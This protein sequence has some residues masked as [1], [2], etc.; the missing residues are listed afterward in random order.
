MASILGD[1]YYGFGNDG[2]VWYDLIYELVD[3]INE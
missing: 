2:V 1:S 3:N